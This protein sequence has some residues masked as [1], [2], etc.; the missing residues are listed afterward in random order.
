MENLD[1]KHIDMLRTSLSVYEV[2]G[3]QC[4]LTFQKKTMTLD[5]SSSLSF[6]NPH[7]SLLFSSQLIAVRVLLNMIRIKFHYISKNIFENL[8]IL[9]SLVN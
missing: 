1:D 5:V 9:I 2:D 8:I 4:Q 6:F 7:Q 3:I